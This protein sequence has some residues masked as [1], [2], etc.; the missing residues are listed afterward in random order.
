[1]PPAYTSPSPTSAFAQS[2]F[3]SEKESPNSS[4]SGSDDGTLSPTQTAGPLTL[5]PDD[6]RMAASSNDSDVGPALRLMRKGSNSE[7]KKGDSNDL[8]FSP[9]QYIFEGQGPTVA[10][11]APAQ[12][13]PPKS[14]TPPGMISMVPMQTPSSPQMPIIPTTPVTTMSPDELL[15]AYAERRAAAGSRG[16]SASPRLQISAPII[17][18]S[19]IMGQQI[20]SPMSP[21]SAAYHTNNP[22]STTYGTSSGGNMRTIYAG[23]NAAGV[24]VGAGASR[25]NNTGPVTNA[26][27]SVRH[28]A[29]LYSVGSYSAAT[30]I[31]D[32]HDQAYGGRH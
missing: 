23:S 28:S 17:T 4:E 11:P 26:S 14:H 12:T 29:S 9:S 7:H 21:I 6:I 19:Y 18:D 1:M 3:P 10:V 16:P 2:N 15:R 31:D 24:G 27:E 25:S 30:D 32:D 5:S 20:G 13:R 22:I 8:L